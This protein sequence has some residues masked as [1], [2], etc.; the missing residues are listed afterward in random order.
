MRQNRSEVFLEVARS[1]CPVCGRLVDADVLVRDNRVFFRK[2]CPDHGHSEAL[3]S[4]DLEHYRFSLMFN[5]PGAVPAGFHSR[6]ARGCPHDCGLCP[7]HQQHTCLA[8]VE[9]TNA[10]DLECP[11]CFAAAGAAPVRHVPLATVREMLSRYRTAEGSPEVVQISGG[12]P[13]LHPELFAV[14]TAARDMGI[15]TVQLNTN[16]L[17]IAR[18]PDFV[19]RL[20]ELKPSVYLQFDGFRP[21][22]YELIRG[23]DL[24]ADKMKAVDRLASHGFTIVLAVTVVE[25][26]NDGE[27]GEITRFA[28]EHPRIRGVI[29]QPAACTGRYLPPFTP[30]QRITLPDVL[31]AVEEQ[32]GGLLTRRDFIPVPCPFPTCFSVTYV[33]NS[34]DGVTTLPRLI[35]VDDYLDYFKNRIITNL[36]PLT[37]AALENL[38]SAGATPGSDRTLK[39]FACCCGVAPEVLKELEDAI[40]MVGVH[41]LMDRHSFDLKRAKKCCIHQLLPDGRIVPFCVYNN[42]E[43]GRSDG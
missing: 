39:D 5:K 10:C 3:V 12:E 4:S 36:D 40:T 29:F 16:G 13:T 2:F 15:G 9:I 17:R 32:T 34:D 18:D 6:T 7:E 31:R 35:N 37:Q 1:L 28:I 41:A 22:T 14:I 23:R 30:T 25:G 33:Y 8:L 19:E 24:A 27:I 42:L 38:W 26:V 11:V 43:R 21:A 20:A